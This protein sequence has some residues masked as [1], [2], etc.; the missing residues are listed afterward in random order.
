VSLHADAPLRDCRRPLRLHRA[1]TV[2][3]GLIRQL[4]GR[5]LLDSEDVVLLADEIVCLRDRAG[6]AANI[7]RAH[8]ARL[9]LDLTEQLRL[10]V[11]LARACAWLEAKAILGT[12]PGWHRERLRYLRDHTRPWVSHSAMSEFDR[13]GLGWDWLDPA[14]VGKFRRGGGR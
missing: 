3:D 2:R 13:A 10:F 1:R 7:L 9:S 11:R 14:L 12:S 8:C 6:Q 5:M 4:A